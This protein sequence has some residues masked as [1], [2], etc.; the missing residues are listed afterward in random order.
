VEIDDGGN[1]LEWWILRYGNTRGTALPTTTYSHDLSVNPL[2]FPEHKKRLASFIQALPQ[3]RAMR[4][5]YLP[6]RQAERI[7]SGQGLKID[8][9]YYY[10]LAREKTMDANSDGLALVTV[11]ERDSWT[12]RTF[13]YFNY[14]DLGVIKK[15]VLKAV[16][17]TNDDLIRL[18]RRFCPDWMVQ[19]DGTFNTNKIKMPLTDVL[20]VTNTGNSFIFAFSFVTSESAHNWGFTLQCLGHVVF[21]ADRFQTRVLSVRL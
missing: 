18:A 19:M 16:S 12:Y 9:Q 3:A 21:E 1:R 20:G 2:I 7:L 13:W 10:N 5:S 6:F 17:Y 14:S 8:R 4:E 15:Q 11:L